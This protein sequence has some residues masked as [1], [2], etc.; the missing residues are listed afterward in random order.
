M[1][2]TAKMKMSEAV[3]CAA[4]AVV[5]TGT[6]ILLFVHLVFTAPVVA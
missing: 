1:M 6:T 4:L 5:T 3:A 2:G